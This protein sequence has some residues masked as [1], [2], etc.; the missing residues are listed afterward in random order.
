MNDSRRQFL[1]TAVLGSGGALCSLPAVVEQTSNELKTPEAKDRS[2]AE[3]RTEHL[4]D[5]VNVLQGMSSSPEFSRGNTLP[6]VAAP[7]GMGHWTLQTT[8]Q[9]GPWFFHPEERR[10]EGI[11]CTHQLSPWLG[12]YGS[13]TL[14]PFTGSP[15]LEAGARVSSYR[16]EE[17][18]LTP[19]SMHL[20]LVRYGITIDLAPT[21]RC[22]AMDL[23]FTRKGSTGLCI[24]LPG[25]CWHL[26][27]AHRQGGSQKAAIP[28]S[29]VLSSFKFCSHTAVLSKRDEW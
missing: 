15:N 11:R 10:L 18:R 20:R 13:A 8:S 25:A 6:I 27:R 5:L 29:D 17:L 1:K 7:F 2:R 21:E 4:A 23:T 9:R 24:A 26:F 16:P 3:G 12:D 22:M 28:R 19:Y 14:L